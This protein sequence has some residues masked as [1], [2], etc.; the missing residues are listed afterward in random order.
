M[1]ETKQTDI[2]SD[3]TSS[4]ISA[5]ELHRLTVE[6]ATQIDRKEWQTAEPLCQRI[7]ELCYHHYPAIY[8]MAC[9][10]EQ[11][12]RVEQALKGF[13]TALAM[14]LWEEK[15]F[16]RFCR[17]A[18]KHNKLSHFTSQAEIVLTTQGPF[19]T[20]S[21]HGHTLKTKALGGTESALIYMARE[22]ARLEKKVEVY[23][24][25]HE[26]GVYDGVIYRN[27]IDFGIVNRLSKP[28]VVVACRNDHYLQNCTRA[29]Q[30]WLWIHDRATGVFNHLGDESPLLNHSRFEHVF[31]L[32]QYQKN[33][34]MRAYA[35]PENKFVCTSNGFDPE[36]FFP[37][38]QQRPL[39]LIYTSRP[40]RGLRTALDCVERLR[41][42]YPNLVLKV[43]TYTYEK[44]LAEDDEWKPFLEDLKK[45]WVVSLGTLTKAELAHE[46][47]HS[48]LLLY[49]NT[50]LAETSCIAA[51]EA[52]ACGCPVITS[53]NGALPETVP[54]RVGGLV[55]RFTDNR[56]ELT[57]A[58]CEAVTTLFQDDPFMDVLR[59]SAVRHVQA[60]YPWGHVARQWLALFEQEAQG[61]PL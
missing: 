52:M 21:F 48:S 33:D 24:T 47:R 26:P 51:I 3:K 18:E 57:Q 34:W 45:P 43:C 30:R 31:C 8:L 44:S 29:T 60:C 9:I 6:V 59:Q 61:V 12:G 42:K 11:Q 4:D 22:L 37:G 50:S 46:L 49:P 28:P 27:N 14:K 54:H 13:A 56:E 20:Q 2:F 25:C 39:S 40:H 55:V 38:P 53:D 41:T 58:L 16:Q 19:Q 7:L 32:S 5:E 17:L 35:M 1:C 15:P 23:C 36:I 10:H